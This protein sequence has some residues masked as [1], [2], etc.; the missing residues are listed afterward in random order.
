MQDTIST[1]NGWCNRET[2][3]VSLWLS[4]DEA[5]YSFLQD[6]SHK[7]GT[8]YDKADWLENEM[9]ETCDQLY[10]QG[11]LWADLISTSLSRVNWYE[12]IENS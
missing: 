3:L 7:A 8:L 11:N 12:L 10:Q 9:R 1:Y 2:W 5:C 4:N 6:A